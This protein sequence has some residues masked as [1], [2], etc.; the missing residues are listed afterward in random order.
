MPSTRKQKAKAKRS[1]LSDVM[2]GNYPRSQ[3]DDEIDENVDIDSRSNGSR[4]DMVRNCKEY[5]SQVNTES[6]SENGIATDIT[7]LISTEISQQVTRKLD[8]MKRNLN[9]QITESIN[10]A[11]HETVLPTL[12]SSLSDQNSRLGTSVD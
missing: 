7:M 5:R 9:T 3:L 12:Q 2:V 11:I 8:E 10:S 6:R 4:Q 1:G